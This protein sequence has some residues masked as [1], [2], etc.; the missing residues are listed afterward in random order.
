MFQIMLRSDNHINRFCSL[1]ISHWYV[2]ILTAPTSLFYLTAFPSDEIWSQDQYLQNDTENKNLQEFEM[3]GDKCTDTFLH[4]IMR[5]AATLGLAL[6][7]H[8][9]VE[10]RKI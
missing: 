4:Y 9:V 1:H 3:N 5:L 8:A 2:E 10:E 7:M 6:S